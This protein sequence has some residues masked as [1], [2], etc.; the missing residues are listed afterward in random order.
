MCLLSYLLIHVTNVYIPGAASDKVVALE[1]A[2]AI[3]SDSPAKIGSLLLKV[4][5]HFVHHVP[6]FELSEHIGHARCRSCIIRSGF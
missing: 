3:V 6:S 4:R 1:K 5:P 2:G